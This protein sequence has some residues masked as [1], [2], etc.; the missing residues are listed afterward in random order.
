MLDALG[1]RQAIGKDHQRIARH[2]LYRAIVVLGA[3]DDAEDKVGLTKL[4][5][6]IVLD[7]QR[8][9]MTGVRV[10]DHARSRVEPAEEQGDEFGLRQV[11]FQRH[12]QLHHQLRRP[13]IVL[14]EDSK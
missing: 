13:G 9:R 14:G 6:G 3:A 1:F 10:F 7:Q 12:I 2:Q 4:L 11:L 8:R 5:D